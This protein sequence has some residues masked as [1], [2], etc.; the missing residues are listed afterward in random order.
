MK[1]ILDNLVFAWQKMGGISIFW[2]NIIQ[3]VLQRFDPEQVRNGHVLARTMYVAI[4]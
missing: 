3:M 4:W 2:E 1:I